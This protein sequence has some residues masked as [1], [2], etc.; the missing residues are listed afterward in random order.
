MLEE[1]L[2]GPL[3][4]I[5]LARERTTKCAVVLKCLSKE[6]IVVHDMKH[7]IQREIELHMFCKH[8]HIVRM[9][10]YFGMSVSSLCWTIVK[11][12]TSIDGSANAWSSATDCRGRQWAKQLVQAVAYCT[13]IDFS[14]E[15]LNREHFAEK[16]N[17]KL[18]DYMGRISTDD[19]STVA[20]R[21]RQTLCGTL[22]YLSP[23]VLDAQQDGYDERTDMWSVGAV[24][25]EMLYGYPPFETSEV[26][27]TCECIRSGKIQYRNNDAVNV[28]LPPHVGSFLAG[29]LSI[30]DLRLTAEQ[31]LRHP[32]L[33]DD[34]SPKGA[35][36]WCH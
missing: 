11:V 20:V 18:A 12:E 35:F 28:V 14:I 7:Q 10:A 31:A 36:R 4:K 22:D 27:T 30:T 17:V 21:R 16:G 13:T 26:R 6:A 29:L 1:R 9:L 3:R 25:F 23:Q 19:T 15:T 24:V 5:Y 8:R 2:E 32:F 34:A 33:F